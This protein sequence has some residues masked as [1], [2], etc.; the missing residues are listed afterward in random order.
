[1]VS[2]VS[3]RYQRKS[4]GE[5]FTYVAKIH[6]EVDAFSAKVFDANGELAGTPLLFFAGTSGL[7]EAQCREW[8]ERCIR[9]KEGVA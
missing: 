4:D 6:L 1:M 9:N 5:Y 8:V 3:G 2:V 7:V